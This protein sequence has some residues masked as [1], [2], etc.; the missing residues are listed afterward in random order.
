M[1]EQFE[2]F[3]VISIKTIKDLGNFNKEESV[4]GPYHLVFGLHFWLGIGSLENITVDKEKVLH[5][6][7]IFITRD[8]QL[9]GQ[10]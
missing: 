4:I 7:T 2:T 1:L 3:L 9:L 5:E 8:A 10:S 6:I